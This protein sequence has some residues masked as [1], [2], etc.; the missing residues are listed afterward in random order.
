M[1]LLNKKCVPCEGGVAPLTQEEA[2]PY[3]EA[4]PGWALSQDNK[5]IWR[6]IVMKDFV[7]AVAFIDQLAKVAESEGH[8]PDIHLTGWNHLKIELW[9]HAIGGLSVND[10]IIAAKA[11]Q[12]LGS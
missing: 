8:H 5:K 6:E 11:N 3:L 4:V 1:D 7:G 12:L 2:K 9:T 10:F